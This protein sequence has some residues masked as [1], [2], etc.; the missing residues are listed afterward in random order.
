MGPTK[1]IW[2]HVIW[3]ESCEFRSIKS[4]LKNVCCGLLCKFTGKCFVKT[5]RLISPKHYTT[6]LHSPSSPRPSIFPLCDYGTTPPRRRRM[7]GTA[8]EVAVFADT[9]LGTRIAFNAPSHITAGT[10]KSNNNLSI[11]FS[12]FYLVYSFINC[13]FVR[14]MIHFL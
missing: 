9:N 14:H 4:V 1:L 3:W 6:L 2:D 11:L 12:C 10:L 7:N 13:T 8:A 5:T